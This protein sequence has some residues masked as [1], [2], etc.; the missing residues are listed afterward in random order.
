MKDTAE[1]HGNVVITRGPNKLEGD[2]AQVNL[3]TNMSKIF[4]N[5]KNNKRVKGVF[6]PSSRKQESVQ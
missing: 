4:G 2:K 1:M 3:K 5:A 6:F